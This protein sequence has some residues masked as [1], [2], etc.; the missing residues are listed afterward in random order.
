MEFT[1][2]KEFF[3]GAIQRLCG[4]SKNESPNY[5]HVGEISIKAEKDRLLLGAS[6]GFISAVQ[7]LKD[8]SLLSIIKEGET[9]II[10]SKL[11]SI[12]KSV[13][14]KQRVKIKTTS[15]N[16][17]REII[18]QKRKLTV[19]IYPKK[20]S[21]S[22]ETIEGKEFSVPADIFNGSIREII[23]CVGEGEYNPVY[24]NVFIEFRKGETRFVCGDGSL[25]AIICNQDNSN[26]HIKT[27]NERNGYIIPSLQAIL[28]PALFE[29]ATVI[30]GTFS[31]KTYYFETDTGLKVLVN[32]IPLEHVSYIPYEK[33]SDRIAERIVSVEADFKSLSQVVADM[34]AIR[35]REYE[36]RYD[37][38]PVHFTVKDDELTFKSDFTNKLECSIPAH[39][40]KSYDGET[41]ECQDDYALTIFSEIVKFGS[42][43]SYEL[44]FLGKDDVVFCSFPNDPEERKRI[45][46]FTTVADP[47]EE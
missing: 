41:V 31:K 19:P 36:K 1:I 3:L 44:S 12:I 32:G 6:N 46:F 34:D 5:E 8:D 7:E 22:L 37:C 35:D 18:G 27:D 40:F 25:F 33:Q 16:L 11:Q 23:P 10:G 39:N 13:N 29:E 26:K 42:S 2:E 17:V 43:D 47:N 15:E 21:V 38:I 20:A 9:V 14:E 28:L 45:V 4:L 24:K 30:R